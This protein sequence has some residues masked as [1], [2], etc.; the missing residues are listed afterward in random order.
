MCSTD[1]SDGRLCLL[2]SL[3][4]RVKH[5][6]LEELCSVHDV[7]EVCLAQRDNHLVVTTLPARVAARID[8]ISLEIVILRYDTLHGLRWSESNE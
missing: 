3:E 5:V 2:V 1:Q 6:E 4:L 8:H 7:I